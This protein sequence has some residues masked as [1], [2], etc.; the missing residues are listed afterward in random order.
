[1]VGKCNKRRFGGYR[2]LINALRG[3]HGKY[4][5][6]RQRW[7]RIAELKKRIEYADNRTLLF[8]M[9]PVHGNIGDHAIAKAVTDML[10]GMHLKYIEVT[11]SDLLMLSKTI[12]IGK[13]NGKPILVNGGGNLGELWPK[14]ERLFRKV[15][16]KN[17]DSKIICLPNTIYYD[18]TKKGNQELRKSVSIYNRHKSLKICTREKISYDLV[19]K[20]YND[21]VLIPDMVLSM[22]ESKEKYKR[23]GCLVCFRKDKEKTL[24]S[25]EYEKCIAEVK[26][27]FN[28][29]SITDTDSLDYIPIENRNDEIR[30]KLDQFRSAELVVTDRLHG[31]IF[32]AITGT[33]CIVL[34]SRSH[35]VRGCYEWIKNLDNIVLAETKDSITQLYNQIPKQEFCYDNHN[36]QPYFSELKGYISEIV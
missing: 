29:V 13:M 2:V 1:M 15:I 32:S 34:D 11:I 19:R 28:D 24:G 7:K 27:L 33:P 16:I 6:W 17:P 30:K 14:L 4:Y 3:F 9:T 8:T 22:N 36:L 21:V 35:K 23:N 26:T 31:M 5:E 25:E 20:L 18:D 12:S 10:D